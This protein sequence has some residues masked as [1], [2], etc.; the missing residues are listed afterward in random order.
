MANPTSEL[1]NT[2]LRKEFIDSAVKAVVKVEEKFKAMCTIDSSSAWTESYFRETNDDATDTGTGSPIKGLPAFA[3]FPFID[4]SE[5]K[6]S[7]TIDKYA[8]ESIISLE[9]QMNITV[10]MLQRKIY[11]IGRKIIYQVDVAIEAALS[12]DAGQTLAIA[13]GNEW[14][15]ATIANRDPVKDFLDAIQKLRAQGIDALDGSG[16]AVMNGTDYTNVIS[17]TKVLNHPTFKEVSVIKNGRVHMLVGLTIVISEA[18]TADQAYV[19]VEKKGMV[20]KQA[21]ALRVVTTEEVGKWT[22]IRAWERGVFQLQA[23]NEVCKI[24]NTRK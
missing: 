21:E 16:L 15:S 8:G 24:T 9:A 20:W 7:S 12:S 22:T 17:N 13:A 10:P 4:V 5:T 19:L 18:V 3:P 2:D 11:R 14:D 23:P 1:V 6:V